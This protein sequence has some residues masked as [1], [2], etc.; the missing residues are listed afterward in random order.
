MKRK[1]LI[2]GLLWA[3]AAGAQTPWEEVRALPSRVD[4]ICQ[5]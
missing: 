1:F 2:A 5:V 4:G 3:V